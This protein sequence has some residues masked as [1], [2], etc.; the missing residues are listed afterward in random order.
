MPRLVVHIDDYAIAAVSQ[1]F[2]DLI[3]PDSVVLDLMSSWRSH[4][5]SGHPKTRL[6]G[7]GMNAVEMRDN[8]DLDD[9]I[10]H[11]V[12]QDPNLPFP[13]DSFDAVVITVSAQYLT[14]SGGDLRAREPDPQT[15]RGVHSI[16]FQPH[17]SHQG[18]AHLAHGE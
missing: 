9:H 18:G 1:L 13:D 16:I 11:D 7:L 4:W 14:Q 17:V 15:R 12:N 2:R 8:P 10:V 3:H 6:V 5:P